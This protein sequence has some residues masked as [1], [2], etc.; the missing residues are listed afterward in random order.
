MEPIFYIAISFFIVPLAVILMNN[1][2]PKK[3]AERV[4]LQ[5]AGAVSVWQTIASAAG[6]FLLSAS[7]QSNY[8]FS[9]FWEMSDAGAARFS[10]DSVSLALLFCV[11][12]TSLVSV[13][14]ANRT[15]AGK[16]SS[17]V[18]LLMALILG[19]NG[20]VIVTDL[21][22][23]YVFL[24]IA[25]IS[26]FIM[27]AMFKTGTGLEG[28]F[29]YLVMSVLASIFILIGLAFIFMQ[30]GSLEYSQIGMNVLSNLDASQSLLVYAAFVFIIVGFL[31]KTG[32]VPFHFA[33]PDAYQ[34]ADTSVS[35]LLSG[36]VIKI[37][38]IYGLMTL[39]NL[40]H[41]VFVINITLA[42]IGTVS[43]LAGALA[44]L[45]QNDFKRL[46]AY[47]SIS[48]AG[49]ILLGL[50]TGT[51]LGLIGAVLHIFNH[52][53]AKCTLF[54]NA[55][56]L[57]RQTGTFDITE[58]GGLQNK[59]PVTGFS[60]ITAFLSATGIPPFAGFWSKLLIIMALWTGGQTIFAGIALFASIFTAAY[61]LRMVKRVFFG[62]PS[63]KYPDVREIDGAIK[64]SE[65]MLTV[66]TIA[67]GVTFPLLLVY[68]K[69][70]GII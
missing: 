66:V 48:Q 51:V 29:K 50:S 60:S 47:S 58:M 37:A 65:I 38:G 16:R 11:G 44:A 34:S 57:K 64:F 3:S 18:S 31:I 45:R 24:E 28:A 49:Y 39:T 12:F 61:M 70:R 19:L 10:V 2:L 56:A 41:D 53:T 30:T 15:I 27:I 63:D 52:A 6:F 33:I 59:M 36:I 22:S 32:A 5:F 40:F 62:K 17:Y 21:F 23:L 55:E 9:L 46:A 8:S 67:V 35:V 7:R 4:G 13:L 26:S 69:G 68:L 25:G 14:I 43:I 54:S 1:L 42:V 20:M